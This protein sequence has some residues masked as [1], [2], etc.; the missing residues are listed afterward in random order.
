MC[1]RACVCVRERARETERGAARRVR[2]CG[3][4]HPLRPLS[5]RRPP[6]TTTTVHATQA[7]AYVQP[8]LAA[9]VLELTHVCVPVCVRARVLLSQAH[10]SHASI[11]P[12][13]EEAS[14]AWCD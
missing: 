12:R 7:R 2:C 3:L 11:A 4:M 5:L 9:H 8:Y 6:A 10:P 14:G 1:V 13:V